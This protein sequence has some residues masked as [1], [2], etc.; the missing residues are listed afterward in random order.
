MLCSATPVLCHAVLLCDACA[1]LCS[2]GVLSAG[3]DQQPAAHLRWSIGG[4]ARLLAKV[5]LS[6]P[7]MWHFC[8]S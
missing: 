5:G 4:I 2:P 1:V 7:R 6:C 3:C 8:H